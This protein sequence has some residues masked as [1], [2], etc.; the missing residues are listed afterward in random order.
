M[1][2]AMPSLNQ[3]IQRRAVPA[4]TQ[5]A[6]EAPE[7]GCPDHPTYLMERRAC[8]QDFRHFLRWW[9]FK[10]RESGQ[11]I[12]FEHL[13]PGQERAAQM[14]TEHRWL[15]L[16]KAGKLGFTELECAYDGWVALYRQPNA[17]VHIFSMNLSS[18]MELL[19]MVRFGITHLP[20]WLSLPIV[21]A[22][23]AGGDTATRFRLY[24]GPDDE[25]AVISYP[26]VRNAA[27]DMTATH[28]H[29]DELAR[30]Q[31][32]YDTWS[33]V[34]STVAPGGS[35]HLVT[36]GAGDGNATADIWAKA[37][38]GEIPLY[39][40]FEAWDA[41]PRIPEL[42]P[43]E[44]IPEGMDANAYWYRQ[45]E[46]SML[47]HQLDWLAPRTAEDALRGSSEDQFIQEAHWAACIWREIPPLEPNDRTPLI[48]GVDAGVTND[49]FAVVAVSRHPERP[50]SRRE[51]VVR[52][53]KVWQPPANG[54]EIDQKA[55]EDWLRMLCLGGCI[56]GHP[57]AVGV[58][59]AMPGCE[60][61][62]QG[63]RIPA[64]LVVEI[65]YDE[66]QLVG[67]MQSLRRDRVAWC[68]PF[69]QGNTRLLA[70]ADLRFK[71]INRE[72]YHGDD[73]ALN[74][75]IKNAN[76]KIAANE[77]TKLRIIKRS[78]AAKIDLA[79]ALSMAAYE[80]TRLTIENAR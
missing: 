30:M 54:G 18:A 58:L 37:Q 36:R 20:H 68:N 56:N 1:V 32:P 71:I 78:P 72:L 38:T 80:C 41:R 60:A 9:K 8:A 67:M 17:R 35:V 55:V 40:H 43:G 26:A 31:W 59:S 47:P 24:G 39:P 75:H 50:L 29:V 76:A 22:E 16:L 23:R 25:R 34:E 44:T 77:D 14:M 66:Y 45:R 19:A 12:T 21:S 79:V 2:T 27:I 73:P 33:S 57:N 62:A 49:Y 7:S 5:T 46:G 42:K 64:H 52:A 15:F 13:W 10:N 65:A 63:Q 61:C 28:S 4:R 69:N 48:V 53:T 3:V 70:D 51:T 6:A 11:V 74:Q